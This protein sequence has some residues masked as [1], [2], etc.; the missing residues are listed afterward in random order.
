MH[1]PMARSANYCQQGPLWRNIIC[2]FI[3]IA[4]IVALGACTPTR[5]PD[6][7]SRHW[8]LKEGFYWTWERSIDG[9]CASWVAVEDW[10]S[11]QLSVGSPCEGKRQNGYQDAEGLTYFSVEDRIVFRGYW[12]WSS[13]IFNDLIEFDQA[14]NWV[15]TRP[16]PNFLSRAQISEM[17][18]IAATAAR[19]A[20]TNGE[21]RILLRSAERLRVV[22]GI[23]LS[24]SQNG[25]TDEPWAENMSITQE[26]VDPWEAN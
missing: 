18:K 3:A 15:N 23:I 19:N 12:P 16:C 14:G 10:A 17:Q 22:D 2:A 13:E 26:R 9:G 21:R 1:F 5:I 24:S 8:S 7:A 25:C 6:S 20:T 11:I 4:T